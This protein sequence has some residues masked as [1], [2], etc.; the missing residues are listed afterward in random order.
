MLIKLLAAYLAAVNL[1]AFVLYAVDKRR[2]RLNMWRIP[3]ATLLLL[4]FLG[5]SLGGFLGMRVFHHK[6]KHPKF[7]ILLPALLILHLALLMWAAR[8][9]A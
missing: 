6:T 4:P 8:A 3:E 1:A 5:G 2:A 7:Y 9:L